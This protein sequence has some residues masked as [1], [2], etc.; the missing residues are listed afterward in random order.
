MNLK[1]KNSLNNN[2][3]DI[4]NPN[5]KQLVFPEF[6]DIKVSTKTFIVMTNLV[7]DLKKL[8][9][10][11]PITDY[12]FVQKKRGR[13]KK[14][15][16]T[17]PN[18]DVPQG[19]IVTMKYENNIRG[20]DLKQKKSHTKK[21]K[22]KWFRNSFTVVIIID[23]KPINLKIC[24]NGRFQVTGVKY[25]NQVENC[26]KYIW[27]HIKNDEGNIFKFTSGDCLET[28]FIPAMRNIDF[29]VGFLVDRE[30][31]AKYMSTQ[32]D[33]HSLLETSFGYTGVNIKCPIGRDI[34]TLDIK[35]FTFKGSD[36]IESFMKYEDYL[37]LL[38]E[39][40]QQKKIKKERY[41]TFL[42][43]HSGRTIYSGLS[44]LFMRD[45]YYEFLEIIKKAYEQIE[46]R[47][48]V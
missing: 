7:I 32:T 45:S 46:E 41:N 39:K 5:K 10:Y 11:L 24:Q 47:L 27:S 20:I 9:D 35:K 38:P 12:T 14:I 21:K 44:S 48:D 22:S 36:I 30:K 3:T 13:K 42:V 8:F 17:N 15:N 31:L 19:S 34:R 26:I 6:E 2:M 25:D 40:D 28:I 33:F 18:K 29:S 23:D 16:Q 43:F 37:K 4:I 1:K